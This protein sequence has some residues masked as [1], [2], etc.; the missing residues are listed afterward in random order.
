MFDFTT[1][2]S[3]KSSKVANGV[4]VSVR[5][6]EL[7]SINLTNAQITI[8]GI[9]PAYRGLVTITLGDKTHVLHKGDT[10]SIWVSHQKTPEQL[11]AFGEVFNVL[12]ETPDVV[13]GTVT[14]AE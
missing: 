10:H 4:K 8:A 12:T 7:T 11:V 3:K 5:V 2:A 13:Q 6:V 14:I 1:V 9:N